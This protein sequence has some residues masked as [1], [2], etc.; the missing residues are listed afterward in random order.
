MTSKLEEQEKKLNESED[1]RK[2]N[3]YDRPILEM[4]AVLDIGI[5][6]DEKGQFTRWA[7]DMANTLDNVRPGLGA[8]LE[9]L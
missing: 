7:R 1:K 8:M 5:L 9:W 4:K 2:N 3:N 6:G